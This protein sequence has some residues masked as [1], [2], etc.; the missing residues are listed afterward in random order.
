MKYNK[1]GEI[2]WKNQF[3]SDSSDIGRNIYI[4]IYKNIYLSGKTKGNLLC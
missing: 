2:K 1:N 4:D 3:G